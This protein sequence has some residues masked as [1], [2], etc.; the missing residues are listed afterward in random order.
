MNSRSRDPLLPVVQGPLFA[1]RVITVLSWH[2]GHAL[3]SSATVNRRSR[4][5]YVN[6]RSRDP[7]VN[8]RS[9]DLHVPLRSSATVCSSRL[10][11]AS[12][13]RYL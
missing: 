3:R 2:L 1:R 9:R 13:T 12:L 7:Y 6:S 8:I 5:P 11:H 4:D 10:L